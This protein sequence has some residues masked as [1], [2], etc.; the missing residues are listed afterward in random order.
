M[1]DITHNNAYSHKKSTQ[2]HTH[3]LSD[4][5]TETGIILTHTHQKSQHSDTLMQTRIHLNTI[6]RKTVS[7][8]N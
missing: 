8:C 1:I 6:Y 2:K 3:T 7:F 4:T 5:D